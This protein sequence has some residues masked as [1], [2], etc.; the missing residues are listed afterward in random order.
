MDDED[1]SMAIG[2]FQF[3]FS[4]SKIEEKPSGSTTWQDAGLDFGQDNDDEEEQ[5]SMDSGM[6]DTLTNFLANNTKR[7]NLMSEAAG[8]K[9]VWKKLWHA[10]K[11]LNE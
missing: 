2:D 4:E 8:K 3:D 11:G 6:E 7:T 10:A 9:S 1:I 5:D